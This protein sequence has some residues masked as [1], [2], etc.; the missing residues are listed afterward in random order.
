MAVTTTAAT[1]GVM[2]RR[3]YCANRPRTPSST[4][5]TMTAP[6]SAPYPWV[7]ATVQATVTKVKLMPMTMDRPLPTRQ[8]GYSWMNVPMPATIMAFWMSIAVVTSS[9]PAAAAMMAMGARFATNM[10]RTC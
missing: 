8:S 5:P 1:I 2:M 10:A 4:P 6:M 7:A 9:K 3:Q